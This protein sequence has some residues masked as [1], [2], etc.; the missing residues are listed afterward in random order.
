MQVPNWLFSI[1]FVVWTMFC[2]N[3]INR[4]DGIYAQGSGISA[5]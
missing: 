1:G 5:I 4:F 2:I 3:A